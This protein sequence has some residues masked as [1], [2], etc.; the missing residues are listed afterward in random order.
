MQPYGTDNPDDEQVNPD[1]KKIKQSMI[2]EKHISNLLSVH[3]CVIVPGLGGFIAN[4]VPAVIHPVNHTFTPPSRKLAF[5]ARL[6]NNDGILANAVAAGSGVS[7]AEAI[8]QIDS[9]VNALLARLAGGHPLTIAGAGTLAA[10][11][12]GFLSFT[13]EA[14]LN[15][16]DDAFGLTTFTLQPVSRENLE[17]RISRKLAASKAVKP[18]RKLPSTLKWAAVLLPIAAVTLWGVLNTGAFNKLENSYATLFP[19]NTA[20]ITLSETPASNPAKIPELIPVSPEPEII[21]AEVVPEPAPVRPN[22]FFIITGAFGVEENANNLVRDLRSRGYDA[23]IAGQ[24]NQ[25]LYRVSLQGFSNKEEA[26][27]RLEELRNSDFP[28]A[29]LLTRR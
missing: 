2:L 12:D 22:S 14:G 26:L 24:N 11:E 1:A 18:I 10:G 13:P 8:R 16:L 6:R 5:N 9:E 15:L 20:T 29:W 7:Y 21:E 28:G 4:Y 17:T 23:S 19:T 27:I 3:D 25:G